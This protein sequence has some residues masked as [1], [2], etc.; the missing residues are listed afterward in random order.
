MAEK[1]SQSQL[2]FWQHREYHSWESPEE[3]DTTHGGSWG[4]GGAWDPRWLMDHVTYNQ[5]IM[6]LYHKMYYL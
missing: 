4:G 1:G 2:F 6:I 5:F 3:N